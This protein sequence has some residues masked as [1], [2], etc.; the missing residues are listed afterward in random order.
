M[1]RR[2]AGSAPLTLYVSAQSPMPITPF[3]FGPGAAIHALAPRQVSFLAFCAA[4]VLIDIEPLYFMLTH[5]YP[6]HRFFHTLI[7]ALL[8]AILTI[9]LFMGARA[10]A[11]RYWLPN[12]FKWRELGVFAVTIGAILG[13]YSHIVLDSL[14]HSDITPLAPF[15]DANP[16]LKLVALNT[17]HLGCVAAGVV[18]VVILFI[19]QSR[20][21]SAR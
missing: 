20:S 2:K 11:G 1:L 18:G 15:S 3:H 12:L 10:F 9:A 6:V 21:G 7:G 5:Q 17:L 4:N 19:R 8:I 14:M 13:S 16:L